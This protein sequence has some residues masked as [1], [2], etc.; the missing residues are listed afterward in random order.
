MK[1]RSDLLKIQFLFIKFFQVKLV[2]HYVAHMT[3]P[4]FTQQGESPG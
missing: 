2:A 4:G 1:N 3:P